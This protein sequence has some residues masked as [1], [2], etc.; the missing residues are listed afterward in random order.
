MINQV[1]IYQQ[2]GQGYTVTAICALVIATAFIIA[3][4]KKSHDYETCNLLFVSGMAFYIMAA[5][6][7]FDKDKYS[8][9]MID[10]VRAQYTCHVSETAVS[11][12]DGTYSLNN[13]Q[14]FY[15]DD[16][17]ILNIYKENIM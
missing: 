9:Q 12:K 14:Y 11:E 7:F 4:V 5:V 6:L 17:K 16:N 3:S 15:D 2:I 13:N 10:K 8:T 1:E